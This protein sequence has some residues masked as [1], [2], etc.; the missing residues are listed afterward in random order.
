MLVLTRKLGE[1]IIINESIEIMLLR[2]NGAGSIRVGIEAPSY[3]NIARKEILEKFNNKFTHL[4]LIKNDEQ[5]L[6]QK[7]ELIGLKSKMEKLEQNIALY[8]T[9]NVRA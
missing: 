1:S 4:S 3:V 8:E 6:E 5:Y 9:M 7:H 2:T